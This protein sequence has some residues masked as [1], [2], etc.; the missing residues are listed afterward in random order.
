[1]GVQY[2]A[3][4]PLE[5]PVDWTLLLKD[6]GAVIHLAG[7]AHYL[8]PQTKEAEA[9][10]CDINITATRALAEQ[11]AVAGVRRFIYLSSIKV[12]GE[13]TDSHPFSADDPPRP[14]GIY[15][16][17]KLEAEQALGEI[18]DQQGMEL[19]IIRPTLVYGPNVRGN[20]QRLMGLINSGLPLP[21]GGIE[22]RRSMIG[23]GNLCDLIRICITHPAA[24]AHTFLAADGEDVSTPELVR[25]LARH[26]GR[27]PTLI[28]VSS[29]LLKVVGV[30]LRRSEEMQRLTSSLQVDISKT[31]EVLGWMPP[32]PLDE[33]LKAMVSAALDLQAAG[34]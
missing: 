14:E 22:N 34:K 5:Q 24:P 7:V 8:G 32:V 2:A 26:M 30:L 17:S 28:P 3:V 29:A 16:Q 18:C 21:F 1:V 4:G 23:L 13:V 33:G 27:S 15:G 6:V 12:N 25:R 9:R 10:F 11:A 20:L 19:V 31:K